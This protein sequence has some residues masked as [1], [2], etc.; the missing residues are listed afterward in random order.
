MDLVASAF[1]EFILDHTGEFGFIVVNGWI[2]W[3]RA[4]TGR[5]GVEFCWEGRDE[6]G[7][8]IGRGWAE[9]HDD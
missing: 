2:D 9:L 8:V 7:Q 6:G 1:I 4:G 3:R 5:S